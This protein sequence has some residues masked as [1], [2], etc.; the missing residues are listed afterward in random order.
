MMVLM[1]QQTLFRENLNKYF[2]VD[3]WVKTKNFSH[4]LVIIMYGFKFY[5]Q[6][7]PLLSYL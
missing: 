5:L 1:K 2:T 4:L 6:N 7:S 3:V